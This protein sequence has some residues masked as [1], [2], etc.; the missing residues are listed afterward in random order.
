VRHPLERLL[1]AWRFIF[2]NQA[3]RQIMKNFP[4]AN[5]QNSTTEEDR[6]LFNVTWPDFVSQARMDNSSSK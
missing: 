5:P 6:R 3:W 2:Q 1:S 4:D